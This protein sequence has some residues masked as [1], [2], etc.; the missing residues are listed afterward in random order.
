MPL[1]QTARKL[2]EGNPLPDIDMS[3]SKALEERLGELYAKSNKRFMEM[4]GIDLKKY[5]Y[6][7]PA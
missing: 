7:L 5:N 6:K 1:G 3:M 2:Q 4:S